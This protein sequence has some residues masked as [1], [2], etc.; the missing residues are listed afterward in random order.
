MRTSM[1]GLLLAVMLL[2]PALGCVRKGESQSSS[3]R[4][5]VF[6]RFPGA[7]ELCAQHVTGANDRHITW[8]AY[9]TASPPEEVSRFFEQNH[10]GATVE[11]DD[12]ELR[13][14]GP[15]DWVLSVHPRGGRY[16][17]CEVAPKAD[18]ATVIIVSKASR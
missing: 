18:D 11:R 15:E 6:P 3:E 17:T 10:G 5:G 1:T 14:R 8:T 7:R 16:P 4:W 2:L 12:G 13:L 9:A